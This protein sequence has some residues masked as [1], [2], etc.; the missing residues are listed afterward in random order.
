MRRPKVGWSRSPIAEINIKGRREA[1]F[2]V[3]PSVRFSAE[4]R[5]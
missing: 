5:L 2:F 4:K 1:A 3:L